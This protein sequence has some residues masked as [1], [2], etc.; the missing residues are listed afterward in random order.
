MELAQR[1]A[2]L[3]VLD[4]EDGGRRQARLAGKLAVSHLAPLLAEKR[5]E[6]PV[7]RLVHARSMAKSPFRMRNF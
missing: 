5:R 2:L 7:Q 3:A 6:L 4:A 1:D